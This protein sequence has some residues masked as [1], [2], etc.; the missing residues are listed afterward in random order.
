MCARLGLDVVKV[1]VD[2]DISAYS[3]RRRPGF[4]AMK[5]AMKNGE[6]DTL[7]AWHPDR[8]TRQIRELEDLIELIEVTGVTVQTVGAGEY[9]LDTSAGRQM[10]RIL[11]AVAR[12][13]SEHKAERLR[14]KLDELAAAGKPAAGRP[15]FGYRRE[16]PDRKRDQ[17]RLIIDEEEAATLR[18]MAAQVLSGRSLNSIKN[19]LNAR[20]LPTKQGDRWH[21]TTVSKILTNPTVAGLRV[22]RRQIAGPGE[23][24]PI[25][26][27]DEWEEICATV[28]DPARKR[29]RPAR[30]YVLAGL[31]QSEAGDQMHGSPDLTASVYRTGTPAK[32]QTF[33]K[34]ERLE[35]YV[36]AKVLIALA[37]WHPGLEPEP[38]PGAAEV[39]RL[40]GELAELAKLRGEEVISM[41]EWLTVRKPLTAALEKARAEA[42]RSRPTPALLAKGTIVDSWGTATVEDR[43]QAIAA[44]VDHVTVLPA[45]RGRWSTMDERV[46]IEWRA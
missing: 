30:K 43:R 15:A 16:F 13:E 35:E 26:T 36:V 6:F 37:D 1:F 3:G 21:H 19:E 24:E 10:A 7:V 11:G 33:I 23:Q 2:N 41:Q 9:R 44:V 38:G 18:W 45:T 29:N 42:G 28:A 31:V 4:D 34:A 20:H 46:R 17:G 14:S 27:R 25:F 39:T 22:H 32:V 5:N 8:L 12:G 40:E